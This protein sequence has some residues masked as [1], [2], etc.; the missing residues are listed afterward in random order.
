MKKILLVKLVAFII[1]AF[2]FTGCS[3]N[4]YHTEISKLHSGMSKNEMIDALGIPYGITA[5][6]ATFFIY[7]K[8][9]TN[10]M[11]AVLFTN[12]GT[13]GWL[14]LEVP[15]TGPSGTFAYYKVKKCSDDASLSGIK[16]LGNLIIRDW[17]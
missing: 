17:Q 9:G 13:G 12:Q 8:S 15:S 10:S 14:V 5:A 2:E 6:G 11:L 3:S 16:Y 4:P 1:I 7:Y